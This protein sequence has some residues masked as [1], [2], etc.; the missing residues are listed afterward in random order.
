MYLY[1]LFSSLGSGLHT[2]QYV[3][4]E[5]IIEG[6]DFEAYTSILVVTA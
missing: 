3:D 1:V 4:T 5:I 2:T 6:L